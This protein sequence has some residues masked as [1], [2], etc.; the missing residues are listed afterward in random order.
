MPQVPTQKVAVNQ[1]RFFFSR[2]AEEGNYPTLG[3]GNAK[4]E[5]YTD[6]S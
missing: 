1:I 6:I 2:L 5:I 4:D 3:D